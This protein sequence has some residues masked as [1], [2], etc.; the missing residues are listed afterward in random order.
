MLK[1]I[2]HEVIE[3][4]RKAIEMAGGTFIGTDRRNRHPHISFE[5]GGKRYKHYFPMTPGDSRS[6]LNNLSQL[7]V[8]LRS[9]SNP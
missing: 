2:K 7:K 9:I 3:P 4:Y 1:G 6:H 8:R 5:M